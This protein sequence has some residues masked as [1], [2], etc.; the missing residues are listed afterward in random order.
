ML[1]FHARIGGFGDGDIGVDIFF[2]LSGFLI[3]S[4]LLSRNKPGGRF[5][6][7]DFY[8][9]RALRLLPA[10]FAV[11]IFCVLLEFT[12]SYGGTFK[13]AAVSSV[14]MANW[15]AG[16]TGTGLGMLGH[17]WSLSIEEQFYLVWPALLYLLL[18]RLG[19]NGRSLLAAVAGLVVLAWLLVVGLA[20]IGAPP[21][22]TSNATPTRAVELL[23]GA[24]LAIFVATPSLSGALPKVR[25]VSPVSIAGVLA[26]L[27]LLAM[28][29]ITGTS[30]NVNFIIGWPLI[31]ILTCTVIY[32]C[33]RA[34]T[35]VTAPL[36]TRFMTGVGKRSYGLYLWHFPIFVAIDT[37]WGLGHWSAKLAA[38]AI[39]AV[40]VMLSYRYIERPFLERKDR[41]RPTAEPAPTVAAEPA[42]RIAAET[43]A[44]V[45]AQS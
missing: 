42:P 44:L 20:V 23:I 18:R 41:R 35:P 6:F 28:L 7:A 13:G 4:I 33:L 10:Y 19:W 17:T 36:G 11:L 12:G 34:A 3:T 24:L 21:R 27:G 30:E 38:I 9:R 8:R 31:S 2:V 39:T 40:V 25:A 29:A 15:A 43:P 16:L 22:I 32:A 26:G 45:G 5:N 1:L 37:R 14:Y